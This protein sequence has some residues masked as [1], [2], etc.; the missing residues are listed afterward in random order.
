MEVLEG[1][2]CITRCLDLSTFDRALHPTVPKL[3][4]YLQDDANSPNLDKLIHC[5]GSSVAMPEL[6]DATYEDL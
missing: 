2:H 3:Q 1:T 6:L 5:V 4:G